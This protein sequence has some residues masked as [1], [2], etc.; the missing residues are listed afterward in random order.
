MSD[1]TE[2][3]YRPA[4]LGHLS[5][6]EQLDQL[7]RIVRPFDWVAG[8]AIVLGIVALVGWSVVGRVATRVS[9]EGILVG[10]SAAVIDVSSGVAGRLA[11]LRVAAGDRV[12]R[13]QIVALID[14]TETEQ[15]YHSALEDVREREREHAQLSA[16]LRREIDAKEAQVAAHQSLLDQT[17]ALAEQRAA[18]LTS[19]IAQLEADAAPTI[20]SRRVAEDM[21][22]DLA[23]VQQRI[24]DARIESLRLQAQRIDLMTRGE[25]ELLNAKF[26]VDEAQHR[27]NQLAA[28]LKQDSALTSPADGRVIE[29]KMAEGAILAAGNP[30]IEIEREGAGLSALIYVPADRGKTVKPGM[31]AHIE[32]ASARREEHGLAIGTVSSVSEYPVTPQ[33]MAAVLRNETL[34]AR[35]ARDGASYAVV[36]ELEA[37]GRSASGYRWSSGGGPP[38]RLTPG[39]LARA[40]ITT[41]ERPPIELFAP[42]F[43]RLFGP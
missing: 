17:I 14:Q 43:K 28:T 6:P 2:R 36:I 11:A 20:E 31:R 10:K 29:I 5:S 38:S 9:G 24:G 32:P 22:R 23:G 4:A 39:T 16:T 1:A 12:T 41:A 25:R 40:D 27:A 7:V 19:A 34:V 21:R 13:D 33:G 15:R 3:L 42:F 30:V 35:F 26:R 18:H 37:D 8:V